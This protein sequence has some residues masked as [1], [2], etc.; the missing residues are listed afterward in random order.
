MAKAD[1]HSQQVLMVD[2]QLASY[3][4]QRASWGLV[5]DSESPDLYLVLRTK[6]GKL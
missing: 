2:L 4:K 3:D 5:R 1:T 6:D